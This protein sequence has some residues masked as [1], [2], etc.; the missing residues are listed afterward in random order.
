[1]LFFG[2]GKLKAVRQADSQL[3]P[4]LVDEVS[5]ATRALK[6]PTSLLRLC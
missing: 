5:F 1:M 4:P 2:V 3:L 6:T